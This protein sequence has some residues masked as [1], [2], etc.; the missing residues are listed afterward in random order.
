MNAGILGIGSYVPDRVVPNAAL[1]RATGLSDA[2]V[3]ERLGIEQRRHCGVGE[4]VTTMAAKALLDACKKVGIAPCEID[5]LVTSTTTPGRLMPGL[6][7]D[8]IAAVGLDLR[9]APV[10]VVGAGCAGA[11]QILQL[12]ESLVRSGAGTVAVVQSE[13][14]STLMDFDNIGPGE[15]LALAATIFSDGACCWLLRQCR[16]GTGLLYGSSRTDPAG[17]E[18][19][20]LTGQDLH[21][22]T[23]DAQ[24]VKAFATSRVPALI[25][26]LEAG[27]GITV[28]QAD[29]VLLHQANL[30]LIENVLAAL[31]VPA[32]KSCT[33]VQDLGNTVSASVGLTAARAI[34]TGLLVPGTTVFLAAFGA[35]WTTAGSVLRWCDGTDFVD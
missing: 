28:G 29:L 31:D 4:D 12:G 27:S 22:F 32:E 25:R 24:A 21:G 10:D 34:D 19:L 1:E 8:L 18:G 33:T 9:M 6:G 13:A 17:Y 26:D 30:R 23:M 5:A 16:E 7:S 3:R 14:N 35:G 20:A 2:W 15:G 11:V